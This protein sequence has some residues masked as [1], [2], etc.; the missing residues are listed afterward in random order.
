MLLNYA[1]ELLFGA[2]PVFIPSTNRLLRWSGLLL[3]AVA[4]TILGGGVISESLLQRATMQAAEEELGNLTR[5]FAQNAEDMLEVADAALVTARRLIEADPTPTGLARTRDVLMMRD[6]T[7]RSRELYIIGADGAWLAQSSRLDASSAD[8]ADR[9]FFTFHRGSGDRGLHVGHAIRSRG[10]GRWVLPLSRRIDKADGSFG[11]VVLAT[12]DLETIAAGYAQVASER[13]LTVS[14]LHRDGTL[15]VRHPFE[16]GDIGVQLMSSEARPE[17]G[18]TYRRS[19]IDGV[20]R[21]MAFRRSIRHPIAVVAT[22]AVNDVRGEWVL[23]AAQRMGLR[24]VVV[25]SL[26]VLGLR[27][28]REIRHHHRTAA[29]LAAREAEFRLLA[30]GSSDLVLRL[31]LDGRIRYASPAARR[32]LGQDAEA[33]VGR[34]LVE[35]AACGDADRLA[36]AFDALG[37]GRIEET[38]VT[39]RRVASVGEPG[40]VEA[41][42]AALGADGAR[43][44]DVSLRVV[45][46]GRDRALIAVARDDTEDEEAVLRLASEALTDPLTGLANR[47]RFDEALVGEWRRAARQRA[48]L[49][50]LFVDVDRF[51]RFNDLYGHQRGDS[52]LHAVAQAIRACALRPGDLVARYGGE[53]FVLLLPDTDSDG[54]SHLGEAVRHAVEALALPHAGNGRPGV[55]T[56]S[57]GVAAAA[58]AEDDGLSPDHLAR[59]ADLALYVAKDAGRNRVMTSDGLVAED[60]VAWSG[61]HTPPQRPVR[62]AG[63][64]A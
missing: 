53:E 26:L 8:S 64:R 48:P 63:R 7:E 60:D 41:G 62:R 61:D 19:L 13:R 9:A 30:E 12:V 25:G 52:C 29:A 37:A 46:T 56:V 55:V 14:L 44:L 42:T 17:P 15:L 21:M 2:T 51:K 23:A 22:E 45:A 31:D 24:I 35:F 4:L 49:A 34:S 38:K 20:D 10:T 50:L 1:N 58:P 3:F 40:A 32:V 47:R 18:I 11:G 54:A 59:R 39:F 57:V 27:V 43:W 5:L 36:G 33:V 6:T 28:S 16:A